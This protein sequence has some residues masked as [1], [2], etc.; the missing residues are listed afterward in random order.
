MPLRIGW[1]LQDYVLMCQMQ[2]RVTWPEIQEAERFVVDLM[3][4]TQRPLHVVV[5]GFALTSVP[6][7]HDLH[8]AN[9]PQH[10]LLKS[11]MLIGWGQ[12]PASHAV[13]H[14][15]KAVPKPSRVCASLREATETIRQL[16]PALPTPSADRT[17]IFLLT[18]NH[19]RQQRIG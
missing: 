14:I 3:S 4:R 13:N 19:T 6:S 9:L 12:R 2:G 18:I 11:V 5:D 10:P 15:L 8:R 7:L 17:I 1:Y 16:D